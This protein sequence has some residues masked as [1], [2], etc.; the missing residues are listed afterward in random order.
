VL[1]TLEYLQRGGRIGRAR[2]LLGTML[3]VKPLIGVRDGQL[4]PLENVRTRGKAQ[5]RIGQLV[6]EMGPLESLSIVQADTAAGDALETIIRRTWQGPI[7][8]S[9]LGP[10]VGT[11]AGPGAAGVAVVLQPL[12]A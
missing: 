11:H 7:E 10:V 12:G 3:S 2:A 1:D 9:V 6:A 8:H 5:E 4:V